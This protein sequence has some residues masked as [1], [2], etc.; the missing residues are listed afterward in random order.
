MLVQSIQSYTQTTVYYS[1]E[2]LPQA[3]L[4]T[5][6]ANELSSNVTLPIIEKQLTRRPDASKRDQ[7]WIVVETSK[8][9]DLILAVTNGDNGA[10]PVFICPSSSCQCITEF[11][12]P[13]LHLLAHA[14][15]AA[16]PVRR[17]YS[18]FAPDV[19]AHGFISCW[20]ML[21]GVRAEPAPYYHAMFSYCTRKSIASQRQ[22]TMFPGLVIELRPAVDRDVNAVAS[23]CFQFAADSAPFFLTEAKALV[24]AQ[25]LI[26][27]QQVW[28]HTIRRTEDPIC[29]EEVASIAA[30][31]RNSDHVAT[32]TKV[33]T[34]PHWRRRGCAERL[35]RRVTRHLLSTKTAV[36]LYVGHDN[37]ARFVYHRCGFLGLANDASLHAGVESWIEIG[38]DQ[39]KVQL[40][41]W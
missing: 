21:T 33:F 5:L 27:Q 37:P 2:D 34:N 23:L 4:D 40:G 10:Y 38:L 28:V 29:N 11:L 25:K 31:T 41:H 39:S 15:R 14:L 7:C 22:L 26:S 30:F 19:I 9:V 3:V 35:V 13:R 8:Q 16:M 36:A 17:V 1:A 6:R 20:T 32:I 12:Q 18:V 24:E